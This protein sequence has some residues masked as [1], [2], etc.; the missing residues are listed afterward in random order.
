MNDVKRRAGGVI[1]LC[2]VAVSLL[3]QFSHAADSDIV[4]S[5]ALL[6]DPA[7]G[8]QLNLSL[9]QREKFAAL[10]NRRE[11][12]ALELANMPPQS[13][14]SSVAGRSKKPSPI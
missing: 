12:E 13:W 2:L 4:G 14:P 8:K 5:V 7:V 6:V 10:V 9:T 1:A 11:N 3:A